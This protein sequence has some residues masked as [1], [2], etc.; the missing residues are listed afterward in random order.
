[1][2]FKRLL[3][4]TLLSSVAFTAFSQSAIIRG[5]SSAGNYVNLQSGTPN[6]DAVATS[7]VS[8]DTL[9][10]TYGYNGTT[11]D[12]WKFSSLATG[13][14]IAK[15]TIAGVGDPCLS[16]EIP[17][18]SVVINITTAATTAL[19]VPSGSTVVYICDFT[20]SVSQVATTANTLKFIQ[21]TGAACVTG[22]TDLTGLFGAGGITAG[23][24]ILVSATSSGS[25]FKT[26]A[27]GG[28]CAVTAIGASA[29]FQ[30]VLT[31]VQQ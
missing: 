17:K 13:V 29:S 22:P 23:I 25:V 21:G 5:E 2:K 15:V 12:R 14:G 8:L 10:F 27:S 6:V 4:A 11:W 18:S 1:M 20:F 3:L 30:G 19:V 7:S 24:P 9:S 26:A 31:F 28:L 16:S